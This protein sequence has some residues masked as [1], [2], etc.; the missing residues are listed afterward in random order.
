MALYVHWSDIIWES[1]QI[2][3]GLSP[4]TSYPMFFLKIKY[5]LLM[6]NSEEY[7]DYEHLGSALELSADQ[8]RYRVV[9]S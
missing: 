3:K 5:I 1:A 9:S 8:R 6:Q 4:Y 7:T 2:Y